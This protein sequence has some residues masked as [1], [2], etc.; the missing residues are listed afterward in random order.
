MP[1][2][3]DLAT[4]I[5][6]LLISNTPIS[7]YS[8]GDRYLALHTEDPTNA[9]DVG[10]LSGDNYARVLIPLSTTQ[11]DKG[12]G[13]VNSEVLVFPVASGTKA[14]PITHASIWDNTVGGTPLTYGALTAPA[15]WTSGSSLSLAVNAFVQLL[16]DTI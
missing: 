11:L 5:S 6:A 3:L 10:E 2:S 16:K 8:G 14:T 9:C 4:K 1:M 15:T 12:K 13:L 7:A